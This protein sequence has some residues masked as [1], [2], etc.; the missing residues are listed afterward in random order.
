VLREYRAHL[1]VDYKAPVGA[2]V[3]AV[4]DGVVLAAGPSGDAGRMIHLRHANGLESEY[5]H[6]SAIS[7]RVGQRV[8]QGDLIGQ[9]GATG[10]VTGPHLDY[11]VKKNGAFINPLT[12][13]RGMPPAEPVPAAEM[14][15]FAEVRD[16][17]FTELTAS[18]VAVGP[19]DSGSP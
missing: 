14:P 16:R 18:T 5:L 12:A 9:V 3:V 17:L 7:V 10:L 1:G 15:K 4:A 6:L 19:G 2:P 13:S 8:R 11:R